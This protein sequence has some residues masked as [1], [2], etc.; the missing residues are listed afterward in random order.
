MKWD[1]PIHPKQHSADK[2]YCI[3]QDTK[4]GNWIAYRMHATTADELG[5]KPT[6]I[7]ARQLCEAHDKR[8][9]ASCDPS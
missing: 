5:V 8:F 3:V 6:D 2:R 4:N 9:G 7:Q 1:V